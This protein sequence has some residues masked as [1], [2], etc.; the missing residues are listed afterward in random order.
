[1]KHTEKIAPLAAAL[2]ALATLACC[3]PVG[4]AAAAAL[5]TVGVVV[6]PLRQWFLGGALV[7][8]VF[9]AVQV[10]RKQR[11]CATGGGGTAWSSILILSA[12]AVI[13]LV[14]ALFPQVIATILADWMP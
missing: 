9:G 6:A 7:L 10:N 13:V 1:M 3:L 2:S 11:A 8:L 14:V 5:A 12:S 4:F